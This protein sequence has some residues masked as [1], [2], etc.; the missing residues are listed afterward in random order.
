VGEAGQLWLKQATRE[1]QR[2]IQGLESVASSLVSGQNMTDFAGESSQHCR[3]K[4]QH[5]H[6]TF[7]DTSAECDMKLL[8][9]LFVMDT[10]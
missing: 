6:C 1:N 3:Y 8:K 4:N 10:S 5:F 2:H 9:R 7:A